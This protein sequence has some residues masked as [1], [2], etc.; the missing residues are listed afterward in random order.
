MSKELGDLGF[1]H[2]GRVPFLVEKNE[3]ADP[4]AI[5]LFRPNAKMFAS[6]DITDLIEE[7][8]LVAGRRGD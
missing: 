3:A 2:L 8:G 6:D 4:V 5:N 7:F 1:G